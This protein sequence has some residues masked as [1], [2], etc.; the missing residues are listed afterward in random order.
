MI[1]CIFNFDGSRR[2]FLLYDL[3]AAFTNYVSNFNLHESAINYISSL[4]F[5][6]EFSRFMLCM[7]MCPH[8]CMLNNLFDENMCIK[9]LALMENRFLTIITLAVGQERFRTLTNSYY[10][11][12][13]GIILG[14]IDFISHI[15]GLICQATVSGGSCFG[16]SGTFK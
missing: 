10:R 2:N 3:V 1:Y 15:H 13:Q 6:C 8:T 5:S 7:L 9:L 16:K 4:L 11:G 14:V 12:T